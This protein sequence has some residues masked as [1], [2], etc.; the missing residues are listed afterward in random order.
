MEAADQRRHQPRRHALMV[1][2]SRD[3]MKEPYMQPLP[4]LLYPAVLKS[5]GGKPQWQKVT[6]TIQYPSTRVTTPRVA[7]LGSVPT[8]RSA[9]ATVA[10]LGGVPTSPFSE[11]SDKLGDQLTVRESLRPVFSAEQQ[12]LCELRLDGKPRLV[13]GVAGSGKTVVL[14][15]WLAR[16]VRRPIRVGRRTGSD[17]GCL[18]QYG[19]VRIAYRNRAFRLAGTQHRCILSLG[20]CPLP[21]CA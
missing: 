20:T 1:I 6:T 4:S 16:T 17:L 14:A 7:E 3:E 12:R 9:L 10:E 18:R 19:L 13:R 2:A 21:S 15:H 8:D 5:R 11:D